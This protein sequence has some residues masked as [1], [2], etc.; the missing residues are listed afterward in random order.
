MATTG[1]SGP[2]RWVLSVLAVIGAVA[3]LKLGREVFLPLVIS[4]LLATVL[5]PAVNYLQ[6]SWRMPRIAAS[7]FAVIGLVAVCILGILWGVW[8]VQS[9]FRDM[10]P[11][12]PLRAN[13][14]AMAAERFLT[15]TSVTAVAPVMPAGYL[16][17]IQRMVPTHQ[18]DELIHYVNAGRADPSTRA[19]RTMRTRVSVLNRDLA[20][21]L[22]PE[23]PQQSVFFK[24]I[25]N[26]L[27][28]EAERV[29]EYI[30][31]A[32]GHTLFI[33]FLVLFILVEGDMLMRRTTAL[34]AANAD[35]SS[36]RVTIATTNA[37]NEMARHIRSYLVWRTV[38]NVCMAIALGFI[39]TQL[40]LRQAW[41]WAVLAGVLTFIPYIGPVIAGLPPIVDALITV[42]PGTALLL[43]GIYLAVLVIEGYIVF[44]LVIGRHMEM[45]A[46]TVM[47]A[48]LFWAFVWGEIGLFLALPLM[49]GLKAI[50][51]H[52]PSWRPWAEL[53]GMEVAPSPGTSGPLAEPA[54]TPPEPLF[55]QDK[56]AHN[57][58]QEKR[59]Q[60]NPQDNGPDGTPTQSKHESER[61]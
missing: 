26:W 12:P 47:L 56:L 51:Y 49:A 27:N 1:L 2:T 5:W 45:N 10:Q 37:L 50:C 9:F 24:Y 55:E 29:P 35:E 16:A 54:P 18:D 52:V 28:T 36:D 7:L 60:S 19:Y 22:L 61:Q 13:P 14:Q 34:F 25:R 44:P 42:G 32:S 8:A 3:A 57:Y 30:W 4:L 59:D 43:I 20:E 58:R 33:L 17:E 53:M 6:R 23:D 31:F 39:Y 40:G 21:H 48:C 15:M 38:I 11:S 41:T 46:T